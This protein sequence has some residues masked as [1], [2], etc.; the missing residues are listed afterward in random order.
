MPLVAHSRTAAKIC[1][2]TDCSLRGSYSHAV[3]CNTA[4]P[5]R[6]RYCA[7]Q[8]TWLITRSLGKAPMQVMAALQEDIDDCDRRGRGAD[9]SVP[10]D[11]RPEDFA[12]IVAAAEEAQDVHDAVAPL[13]AH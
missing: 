6:R 7:E 8:L 13:L 12:G 1:G 3:T 9:A 2:H 4:R 5:R 10:A 11:E